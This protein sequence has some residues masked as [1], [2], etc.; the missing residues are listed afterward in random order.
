MYRLATNRQSANKLTG[1]N[2]ETS[3]IKGGLQ[4][5]WKHSIKAAD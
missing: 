4:C 2:K 1:I 5:I 3:G